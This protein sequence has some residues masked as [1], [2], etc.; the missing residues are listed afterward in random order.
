[1]DPTLELKKIGLK[2]TADI[3]SAKLSPE[4]IKQSDQRILEGYLE[5]QKVDNS[6]F[7]LLEKQAYDQTYNA[8]KN[9]PDEIW[10]DKL[11]ASQFVNGKDFGQIDP[12]QSG[13]NRAI[14]DLRKVTPQPVKQSDFDANLSR[15]GDFV[16]SVFD[17]F[18]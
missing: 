15:Y 14:D 8:L 9:R 16:G 6:D 1:M 4:I 12:H 13:I 2:T 18:L 17:K 3:S 10:D 7:K 11:K 5:R